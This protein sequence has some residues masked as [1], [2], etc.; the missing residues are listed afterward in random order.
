LQSVADRRKPSVK[1]P[2]VSARPDVTFPAALPFA[3]V[4]LVTELQGSSESV[5]LTTMPPSPIM[6]KIS[7]QKVSE[8]VKV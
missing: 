5:T 6:Y 8:S 2:L 3:C 7:K 1:L 4:K